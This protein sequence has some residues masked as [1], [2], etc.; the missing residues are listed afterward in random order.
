MEQMLQTTRNGKEVVV[1]ENSVAKAVAP[2]EEK[3]TGVA[4]KATTE[5]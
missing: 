4:A 1:E 5:A 3:A 2:V